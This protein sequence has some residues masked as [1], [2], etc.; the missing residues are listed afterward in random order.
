VLAQCGQVVSEEGLHHPGRV[1][2]AA[3]AAA[4]RASVAGVLTIDCSAVAGVQRCAHNA[5]HAQAYAGIGG[6]I[7]GSMA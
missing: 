1:E 7:H 2:A 3:A 6:L 5:G 4:A